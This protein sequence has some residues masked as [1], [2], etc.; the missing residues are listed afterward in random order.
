MNAGIYNID[1]SVWGKKRRKDKKGIKAC[2][3]H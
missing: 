3:Q 1:V 2:I